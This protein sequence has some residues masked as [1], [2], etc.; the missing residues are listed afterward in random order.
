ML[1]GLIT[2]KEFENCFAYRAMLSKILRSSDM[3]MSWVMTHNANIIINSSYHGCCQKH[4][5]LVDSQSSPFTYYVTAAHPCI[6]F[7]SERRFRGD[8]HR[9]TQVS[10]SN[11]QKCTIICKLRAIFLAICRPIVKKYKH[12]SYLTYLKYDFITNK[13]LSLEI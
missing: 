12:D 7:I 1:T 5:V 3:Q 9:S 10:G 11:L 6:K 4:N 2:R 8:F 13:T